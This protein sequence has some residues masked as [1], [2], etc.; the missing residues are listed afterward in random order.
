MLHVTPQSW[1]WMYS[2]VQNTRVTSAWGAS[3]TP[4]VAPSWGSWATIIAGSAITT[5]VFDVLVMI[6]NNVA[7]ATTR[8]ALVDIGIDPAGG[9]SFTTI[10]PCLLGGHAGAAN[11][12]IP[13]CYR[14]PLYIP[15]GASIGAR[16][17][18]TVA[19]AFHV[20]VSVFG[21]P[22]RPDAVMC[23]TKVVSF[24]EATATATGQSITAGTTSEGAWTQLGSALATPLWW[25]QTGLTCIDTTMTAQ[26]YT[27]DVGV[28]NA[29]SKKMAMENVLVAFNASEGITHNSAMHPA[30]TKTPAGANVYGR[31]QCQGTADT[32]LSMM[33]WGLG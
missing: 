25:W 13:I 28:G 20:N 14:F 4:G 30:Y 8:N 11:G 16:A 27:L 24:G 7:S 17:M 33:A 6:G 10:I 5:D 26:G 31:V 1:N 15:A 12:G 32:S 21:K 9:T 22:S 19:T 23:G 18:G 3:V 29:S 2:N